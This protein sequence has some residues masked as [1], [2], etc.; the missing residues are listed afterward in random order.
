VQVRVA[1]VDDRR[2]T[3]LTVGGHPLAGAVR[4]QTEPIVDAVRFEIQTY[5]RAGSVADLVLMRTLG[6]SLQDRAWTQLIENVVIDT[7]GRAAPV[8]HT[9]EPLAAS[10][11]AVVQRWAEELVVL[12]KQREVDL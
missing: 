7:G 6:G 8:Q 3:L 2:F 4:M 9:T 11:A 12:R 5:E 1:E 10:E